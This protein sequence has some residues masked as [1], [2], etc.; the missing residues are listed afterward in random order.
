[1]YNQ[2]EFGGLILVD[3]VAHQSA[4]YPDFESI[5]EFG[6]DCFVPLIM[7]SGISR[8]EQVQQL[9]HAGADKVCINTAAYAHPELISEIAHRHGA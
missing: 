2:R 7:G 4:E 5:D 3:V 6:Q 9:L 1:M 8:I